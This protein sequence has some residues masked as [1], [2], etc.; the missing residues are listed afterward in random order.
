MVALAILFLILA[1]IVF[2]V[3]PVALSLGRWQTRRPNLALNSWL[4]V[5]AIG[6]LLCAAALG[7]LVWG[8]VRAEVFGVRMESLLSV[9]GGWFALGAAGAVIA[10][11]LRASDDFG[12]RKDAETQ[13]LRSRWTDWYIDSPF[14]IVTVD[15]SEPSAYSLSGRPPEIYLSVGLRSLLNEDECSA[16]IAH[17]KSHLSRH[18]SLVLRVAAVNSACLPPG[19]PMSRKFKASVLTLLEMI[20]DDDAVRATSA[21]SVQKALA[22][23]GDTGRDDYLRLRSLRVERLHSAAQ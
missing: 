21:A 13:A 5:L 14:R 4:A 19:M 10:L 23:L 15:D 7:A 11:V 8:A 18:H 3:S 6:L 1:G 2:C 22:A 17:E 12:R 9:L 16:V 20:A